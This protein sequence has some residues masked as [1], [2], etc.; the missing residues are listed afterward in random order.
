MATIAATIL[1]VLVEFAGTT[2]D[3]VTCARSSPHVPF[4]PS[5][6]HSESCAKEQHDCHSKTAP[7][8]GADILVLVERPR[9]WEESKKDSALEAIQE[10]YAWEHN[11]EL[12]DAPRVAV[13]RYDVAD[14]DEVGVV[15]DWSSPTPSSESLSFAL[16]SG[17]PGEAGRAGVSSQDS[18]T[19][20]LN[21]LEA[22][23]T[24]WIPRGGVVGRASPAHLQLLRERDLHVVLLIGLGHEGACDGACR[25]ALPQLQERAM[26][27]VA[28]IVDSFEREWNVTVSVLSSSAHYLSILGEP[29]SAVTYADG[30]HFNKALSLQRLIAGG[31]SNSLQAHLLAKG[32]AFRVVGPQKLEGGLGTALLGGGAIHD[33]FSSRCPED[34]CVACSP[35]HGC[36]GPGKERTTNIVS[37]SGAGKEMAGR[38][39]LTDFIRSHGDEMA[40]ESARGGA[41]HK[42]SIQQPPRC[43]W[44]PLSNVATDTVPVWQWAPTKPFLGELIRNGRPVV[45]QNSVVRLWPALSKW[46]WGYLQGRLG[47]GGV[48]AVKCTN[49]FLT[50]DPD[51]RAALKLNISLPFVTRNM[52]SEEFVRCITAPSKCR[53]GFQG[54][55]YFTELPTE[56]AGDTDPDDLLFNTRRDHTAK[57]QFLWVSSPGMITHGHFD[58][59]Y[60][61]FVQLKGRKRF[62]LWLPWQHELLYMYPRVHPMWHKSRVN[63]QEPDLEKF[64]LFGKSHAG[65]VTLEPGDA[66]YIPP[67]T[68]HYVETLDEPSVS[69]STWS[70]DYAL[71][72]HM[73]AVYRHD[74]KFDLIQSQEGGAG[75]GAGASRTHPLQPN[76]ALILSVLHAAPNATALV[77]WCV[78]ACHLLLLW[79]LPHDTGQMY[80]LRLYLDMMV[81]ELYGFNQ[82]GE[83]FARLLHLRFQGLEDLFPPHSNDPLLCGRMGGQIPTAVH[84]HGFVSLDVGIIG[85]HF[86]ALQ[87]EAMDILFFDYVEEISAQVGSYIRRGTDGL[88]YIEVLMGSYT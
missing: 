82:T 87:P 63:F 32:V 84:V 70:H 5:S 71:Y 56:L 43:H 8:A 81:H 12:A 88:L 46:S 49:S 28:T 38:I 34:G 66:L 57:K 9:E 17:A 11:T 23:C 20:A 33:R 13:V 44:K 74:H 41:V 4:A 83:V 50:F 47:R 53:D 36:L 59:D 72:D 2:G 80:A 6:L 19:S 54:H 22:L 30:S 29:G 68:W 77:C 31:V 18:I 65:Q 24:R 55:Y 26:R 78:C 85:P 67:Y 25:A 42:L 69:M 48:A 76:Q 21:V 7:L 51:P 16:E 64:P 52:T 45:L 39:V 27:S 15:A 79:L 86:K 40:S 61:V 73:N 60:N 35:L 14:A 62:T 58:Q 37:V 75:G 3:S 1:L 10:L